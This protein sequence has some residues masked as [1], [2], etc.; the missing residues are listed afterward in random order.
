MRKVPKYLVI[1]VLML[2]YVVN[3]NQMS[4]AETVGSVISQ[5]TISFNQ[6]YIPPID[7]QTTVIPDGNVVVPPSQS[8]TKLPQTGQKS[9]GYLVWIGVVL[10]F[11]SIKL[12]RR[13]TILGGI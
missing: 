13:N 12:R 11:S 3:T 4:H 9:E 7:N 2:L 6:T 5:S 8:S 1:L 10:I